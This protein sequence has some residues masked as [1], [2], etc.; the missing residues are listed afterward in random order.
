MSAEEALEINLVNQIVDERELLNEAKKYI[1]KNHL[2]YK[3]GIIK[4]L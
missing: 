3:I 2:P 1:I 4:N